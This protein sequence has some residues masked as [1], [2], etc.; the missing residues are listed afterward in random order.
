[1]TDSGSDR[2]DFVESDERPTSL[3][4]DRGGVPFYIALAWVGVIVTYVAVMV[5]L[6]LPDLRRWLAP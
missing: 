3:P 6:A 4:Y 2:P 1:M 5:T